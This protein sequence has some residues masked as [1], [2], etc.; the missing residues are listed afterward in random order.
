MPSSNYYA[1]MPLIRDERLR[2]DSDEIARLRRHAGSRVLL[3]HR[4][5]HLINGGPAP[6]PNWHTGPDAHELLA[7][8]F[9]WVLLGHL[10]GA[11]H[12]AVDISPL[13]DADLSARF[14]GAGEFTDLRQVGP[15]LDRRDG[16]IMAYARGLLYWHSRHRFCGVCGSPTE[17]EAGGHVRRCTDTA[18]DTQHFPRT[19]PAIIVLVHHGDK[20]LLGRQS[21]WP[22]GMHS[23]LAGFVE[24]GES[25]EETVIREVYEE[26]G[27]RIAGK[28]IYQSSQPWPFPASLMLGFRAEAESESLSV[29]TQEIEHAA[30]YHRD[31]LLN[32]PQD[33]TFRLPRKDS[34]ARRLVD[35]WLFEGAG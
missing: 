14:G 3:V 25:L 29:D 15:L 24:P 8:S 31:D 7:G 9:T 12:F 23:T 32:S 2:R 34:I 17:S 21:N 18:C 6:A 22:P 27:V 26:A 5:R 4:S 16:A 28:P 33:E 35:E 10:D 1:G 19:D 20:C 11:A 13:D 30:W